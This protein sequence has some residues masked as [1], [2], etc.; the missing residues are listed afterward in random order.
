METPAPV[1]LDA[2]LIQQ[3]RNNV[4]KRRLQAK[5]SNLQKA[6]TQWLIPPKWLVQTTTE[7]LHK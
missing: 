6:R 4:G 7:I 1:S 2:A 3:S 5:V